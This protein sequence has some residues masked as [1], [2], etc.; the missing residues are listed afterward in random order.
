MGLRV[1][2]FHGQVETRSTP[3]RRAPILADDE[4][5]LVR[6]LVP[7]TLEGTADSDGP[8]HVQV[9]RGSLQVQEGQPLPGVGTRLGPWPARLGYTMVLLGESE[10][11]RAKRLSLHVPGGEKGVTALIDWLG[12]GRPQPAPERVAVIDGLVAWYCGEAEAYSLWSAILREAR[13]ALLQAF[14][15]Q[16]PESLEEPAWWLSRAAL[17]DDD[18]YLAAACLK[19]AGSSH[20]EAMLRTLLN[21]PLSPVELQERMSEQLLFLD[22][23]ARLAPAVQELSHP[24]APARPADPVLASVRDQVRNQGRMRSV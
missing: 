2:G 13:L 21:K 11:R 6:L 20:A 19:H 7:E 9:E 18:L 14:G 1:L 12:Q 3:A 23:H 24:A 5:W 15:H 17:S 22:A 4:G 8:R 16:P 10:Q